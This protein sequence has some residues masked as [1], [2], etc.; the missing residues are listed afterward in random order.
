MD[1]TLGSLFW[2]NPGFMQ[3]TLRGWECFAHKGTGEQNAKL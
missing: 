2:V 1:L 3:V